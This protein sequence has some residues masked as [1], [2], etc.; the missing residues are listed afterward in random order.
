[1]EVTCSPE[2]SAPTRATR[3]NIPENGILLEQN[4]CRSQ[5]C[6]N[7]WV[8]DKQVHLLSGGWIQL[9]KT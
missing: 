4:P 5:L 1:M 8:L 9:K 7:Q 6:K 2:T 3:S